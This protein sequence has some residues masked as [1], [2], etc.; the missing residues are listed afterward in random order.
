MKKSTIMYNRKFIFDCK[1]DAEEILRYAKEIAYEY[2]YVTA[3]DM[4]DLI[5]TT[6]TYSESLHGWT[7]NAIER[8]EIGKDYYIDDRDDMNPEYVLCF[9]RCDWEKSKETKVV[10][11]KNMNKS[12]KGL[13]FVY[14][15]KD[16]TEIG[17]ILGA[18]VNLVKDSGHMTKYELYKILNLDATNE[19]K[20]IGW[21]AD[22]CDHVVL[23]FDEG[24]YELYFPP[25]DWHQEEADSIGEP[26]PINVSIG[27]DE[28][29]ENPDIIEQ[30]IATVFKNLSMA[31][32]R[33]VFINII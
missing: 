28:V 13:Y 15:C 14:S 8:A 26:E 23:H 20:N 3:A 25:L 24:A 21:T 22:A 1:E 16:D 29:H 2:G 11:E 7:Q 18:I 33:P 17:G 30:V 9:P 5:G 10:K 4:C 19:D 6:T 12:T 31:K 27:R 32:D